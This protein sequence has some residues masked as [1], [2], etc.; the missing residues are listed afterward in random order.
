V[1]L[2]DAPSGTGGTGATGA[3][4]PRGP[5]QDLRVV[6]FAGKGPA[7][8]AAMLLS[9]LGAQV[10]RIERVPAPE[11][12]PAYRVEHDLLRRGRSDI[13]IDLKSPAGLGLALELIEGADVLIEGYRPGVMEKLGLGP[14]VCLA[15]NPRLV[16][17]R[18][19]GWGQSGPLASAAGHDINFLAV[20]GVLSM[21]GRAG[22]PPTPPANILGDFGG[23]GMLVVVGV[24][25]AALA[26]RSTGR[27]QVVDAAILDGSALLATL[28]FGLRASGQWSDERGTN[29]LDTGAP[30]YDVYE[31]A[32]GRFMAV[33]AVEPRFY[34]NLLRTLDIDD[35]EF[36]NPADRS[37]WPR[38]RERLTEIFRSRTRSEWVERFAG[39]D[40]CTSP[41]LSPDEAA[42]HPHNAERD[43]YV[44]YR[45]VTQ[46][47]PAPRFSA[48]PG[49]IPEPAPAGGNPL[50]AW[51]IEATRVEAL[52][53][54]GIIVGGGGADTPHQPPR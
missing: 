40:A 24:L 15:R 39:V 29:I 25:A 1:G 30:Y 8:F 18:A 36:R 13:G 48:T 19:T 54:D 43:L 5:L 22:E 12:H 3:G 9:D 21:L 2:G 38:L 16:F 42:T 6:E 33:G 17:A 47:A 4:G 49:R 52:L 44:R 51:G 23:G 27:G 11:R 20:S 41:V 28:L 53:A 10:L 37:A 14:D 7:P 35:P 32:D 46:P 45:G 26:A 31:T 34:H 50:G